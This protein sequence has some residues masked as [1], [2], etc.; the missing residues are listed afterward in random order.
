MSV[1]D[2]QGL[3]ST[4]FWSKNLNHFYSQTQCGANKVF[5]CD[6]WNFGQARRQ[7]CCIFNIGKTIRTLSN[8]FIKIFMSKLFDSFIIV[9][10]LNISWVLSKKSYLNKEH[11]KSSDFSTSQSDPIDNSVYADHLYLK[12]LI[13]RQK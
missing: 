9:S 11:K 6:P 8:Y 13:L 1:S 2:C 10:P 5:I 4:F 7:S 3:I 12:L